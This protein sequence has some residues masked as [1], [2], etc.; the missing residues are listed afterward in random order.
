MQ[1]SETTAKVYGALAKAQG[2]IKGATLDAKN[3]HF[4]SDYPTLMSVRDASQEPM[5][6]NELATIQS[7]SAEGNLVRLVTRIVHSSG[8]WIESD[9]LQ[10]QAKDAGP[11][12][13]GSCITYLRRYQL[14]AMLGIAPKEDDGEAA[15]GRAVPA[16]AKPAPAPIAKP[17]LNKLP[18]GRTVAWTEPP[19]P[20][21]KDKPGAF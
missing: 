1:T 2:K 15:E 8:E 13:V 6:Q 11:Q 19:P 16:P 7:P 10:V 21:D 20:S 4:N 5:A 14:S 12:A 3:P 18:S 9:V 17:T